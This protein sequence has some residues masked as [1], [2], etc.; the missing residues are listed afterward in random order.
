[1]IYVILP[2]VALLAAT[3]SGIIGIG[4][5]MPLLATMFYRFALLTAGLKVLRAD[6]FLALRRSS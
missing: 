5:G 3:I 1:M 6:G 2:V 4:G